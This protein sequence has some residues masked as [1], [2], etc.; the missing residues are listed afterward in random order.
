MTCTAWRNSL[1]SRYAL[2]C[3]DVRV[4][5]VTVLIVLCSADCGSDDFCV[6]GIT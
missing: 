4:E 1:M 6:A 3:S 2:F 5:M